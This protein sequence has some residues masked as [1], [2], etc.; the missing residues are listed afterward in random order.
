[1]SQEMTNCNPKTKEE[2]EIQEKV[3][4]EQMLQN[5]AIQLLE[6]NNKET[7]KYPSPQDWVIESDCPVG[8]LV[9]KKDRKGNEYQEFK[10]TNIPRPIWVQSIIHNVAT[11]RISMVIGF[12]D[13]RGRVRYEIIDRRILNGTAAS[14]E[15]KSLTEKGAPINSVNF[16]TLLEL[17][18]LYNKDVEGID[19]QYGVD[20][21][22]WYGEGLNFILAESIGQDKE[23]KQLQSKEDIKH[24]CKKGSLAEWKRIFTE[25][26][27]NHADGK[28]LFAC[29][30]AMSSLLKGVLNAKFEFIPALMI[31]GK[32]GSGKSTIQQLIASMIGAPGLMSKDDGVILTFNTTLNALQTRMSALG[33]VPCMVDEKS[34][35]NEVQGKKICVN[36]LL[37]TINTG[38]KDRLDS[39]SSV[40]GGFKPV[41]CSLVFSGE[42]KEDLSGNTGKQ[43]RLV[44]MYWDGLK[45][46]TDGSLAEKVK[47]QVTS[48]YGHFLPVFINY[49]IENYDSLEDSYEK[50]RGFSRELLR[51]VKVPDDTLVRLLPNLSRSRL[52]CKVI[53]AALS[54]D[55]NTAKSCMEAFDAA[56]MEVYADNIIR[57][58][59]ERIP[60]ALREGIG[61]HMNRFSIPKGMQANDESN[62][63]I[64]NK[65]K[66]PISGEIWGRVFDQ[67][68]YGVYKRYLEDLVNKEFSVGQITKVIS[69]LGGSSKNVSVGHV[70]SP[71][72]CFRL[73]EKEVA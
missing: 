42:T 65:Y 26:V 44:Q 25:A 70:S 52:A 53:L 33:P 32:S 60:R 29:S 7:V 19:F 73:P 13:V 9:W 1:M 62:Y 23:L 41:E 45:G 2:I 12:E 39:T 69:D 14:K 46:E 36:D 21:F 11:H 47:D 30:L 72:W 58:E 31:H 54:V 20:Q 24:Y 8:K 6:E 18:T 57:S 48:H 64:R 50:C 35:E 71:M 37:Y 61:S 66:D 40:V 51:K 38:I 67:G 55:Q 59:A 5:P 17:L 56:A 3:T 63:R 49:L 27:I 10:P 43:Y 28:S 22:G 4:L 34:L 16:R 15:A 68:F